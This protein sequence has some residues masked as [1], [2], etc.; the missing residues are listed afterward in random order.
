MLLRFFCRLTFNT[1]LLLLSAAQAQ[2]D[3]P[4]TARVMELIESRCTYCHGREGESASAVYP[5]LAAQHPDYL[6]KQLQDFR[7]GK[8]ISDTMNDM[9][10]DLQDDDFK[11]LAAWFGSRKPG[12]RRVGDADLAAV[13]KYIYHAGNPFSGVPACTTCHGG[14]GYGTQQLPRLAGQH[15]AYLETQ[16]KEFGKRARTNDNAIMHSV[17]SKLTEL[18]SRAVSVYLGSLQ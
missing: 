13:G 8:R 6:N 10:K 14:N 2:T 11:G 5:R 7:D 18:E 1:T 3:S 4:P 17:A 12:S 9:V 16:L 15:P